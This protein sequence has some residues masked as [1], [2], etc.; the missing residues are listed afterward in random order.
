MRH[1]AGRE[2]TCPLAHDALTGLTAQLVFIASRTSTAA[3]RV[4]DA[5]NRTALAL[6]DKPTGRAGR[7]TQVNVTLRTL[8]ISVAPVPELYLQHLPAPTDML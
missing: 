6:G 8:S 2:A 4:A 3:H 5:R 1:L 7:V